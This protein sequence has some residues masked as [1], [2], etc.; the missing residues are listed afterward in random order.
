MKEIK[1][2]LNNNKESYREKQF[3]I[4]IDGKELKNVDKF[5][6]TAKAFTG[7]ELRNSGF[8]DFN[9]VIKYSADFYAPYFET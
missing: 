8:L 7:E 1:I 3:T 9:N 2:V 4:F 5:T 6:L